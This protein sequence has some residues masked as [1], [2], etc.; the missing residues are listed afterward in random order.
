MHDPILLYIILGYYHVVLLREPEYLADTEAGLDE[1]RV[2][3]RVCISF[4]TIICTEYVHTQ[5]QIWQYFRLKLTMSQLDYA[6]TFIRPIFRV[7]IITRQVVSDLL[8][9]LAGLCVLCGLLVFLFDLLCPQCTAVF[10][11]VDVLQD[12]RY[13]QHKKGNDKHSGNVFNIIVVFRKKI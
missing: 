5:K 11:D 6:N 13:L 2:R 9:F 10:F 3:L 1:A 4:M 12:E 7:V 8:L